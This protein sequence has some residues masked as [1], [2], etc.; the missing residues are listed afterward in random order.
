MTAA[1]TAYRL[2]L[3][4]RPD[5]FGRVAQALAAA[6]TGEVWLDLAAL[7]HSLAD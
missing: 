4:L 6:P 5:T 2:A 3:T 7:R 1:K